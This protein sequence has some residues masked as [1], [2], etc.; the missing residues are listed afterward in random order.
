MKKNTALFL[1]LLL[2]SPLLW[3]QNLPYL[4]RH[5]EY[6]AP[7][8][9]QH[10]QLQVNAAKD[11]IISCSGRS[12]ESGLLQE[13][14]YDSSGNWIGVDRIVLEGAAAI[15]RYNYNNSEVLALY[16]DQD[17]LLNLNR[18][19][20][21]G[22]SLYRN[23]EWH[24]SLLLRVNENQGD[25]VLEWV[26]I[27]TPDFSRLLKVKHFENGQEIGEYRFGYSMEGQLIKEE[28]W[29]QGS[30]SRLV[31]Y[32][33]ED[34]QVYAFILT[35]LMQTRNNLQEKH[36]FQY[37]DDGLYSKEV[38]WVN[39]DNN[40]VVE[41]QVLS[42]NAEGNILEN[43]RIYYSQEGSRQSIHLY[44]YPDSNPESASWKNLSLRIERR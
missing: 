37:Q 35:D 23:Y 22:E 41:R 7:Q 27:Y 10:L 36:F 39:M 33:Y 42:F 13:D 14:H 18:V 2:S 24:D 43:K 26:F 44:S 31:T 16:N 29:S 5:L 11:T 9:D 21:E 8:W 20:S 34:Q 25:K 38:Q 12:I 3:A 30:L 15:R 19:S 1:I 32:Q 6:Q 4:L 28:Q 17:Q 40:Q